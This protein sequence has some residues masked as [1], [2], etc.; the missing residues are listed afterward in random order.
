MRDGQLDNLLN[1]SLMLD[2]NLNPN[3]QT[4][5]VFLQPQKTFDDLYSDLAFKAAFVADVPAPQIRYDIN[6]GRL[7]L[8][9]HQISISPNDRWS[10]GVGNWFLHDGFVDSGDDVISGSF[11]YRINDN[12]GLRTTQYYNAETGRL[13]EQFY[14]LYRDMRSWTAALTLRVINNGSG[15]PLDVGVALSVSLKAMPRFH[16][17]GDTVRPYELL[18]Q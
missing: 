16:V 11:F 8:A 1:W 10:V 17:G 6:D 18:G 7:N 13:Q 14:S 2:W 4:N 12:W 3:G 9:F 5:S 15:Q